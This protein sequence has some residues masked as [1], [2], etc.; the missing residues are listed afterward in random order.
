M[1]FLDIRTFKHRTYWGETT[2][3]QATYELHC[4]CSAHMLFVLV[5]WFFR[6]LFYSSR[7]LCP[8][9]YQQAIWLSGHTSSPEISFPFPFSFLHILFGGFC[10]IACVAP[11]DDDDNNGCC[12]CIPYRRPLTVATDANTSNNNNSSALSV[13]ACK[14]QAYYMCHNVHICSDR[15]INII[16]ERC[17]ILI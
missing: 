1:T 14:N 2:Y 4:S 9:F 13:D 3:G 7:R 15:K 10:C 8:L 12:M 16:I 17:S 6:L 11:I 5:F